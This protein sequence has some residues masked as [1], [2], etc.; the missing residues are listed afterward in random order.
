MY[1]LISIIMSIFSLLL[2]S[3]GDYKMNVIINN[4]K[5]DVVLEN[6]NTSKEF[7]NM[8]P[9]KYKMKELN[10]NEK[11]IYLDKKIISSPSYYETINKGDI[12]L[13][14][15]NCI[16]IFYKTFNTNYSYTKIGH[17]DDLDDLSSEDIE[18]YFERKWR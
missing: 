3:N 2:N 8:L 6:N 17:I 14:Q 13:F 15:D 4:K 16:V 12:M 7:I 10:G 5:Y 11:Y 1:K 9:V 18:V